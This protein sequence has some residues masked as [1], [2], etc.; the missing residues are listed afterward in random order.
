MCY[1]EYER[2]LLD[3]RFLRNLPGKENTTTSLDLPSTNDI[4]CLHEIH[5]KDEFEPGWLTRIFL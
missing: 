1:L 3:P 2:G 4:V 5:G